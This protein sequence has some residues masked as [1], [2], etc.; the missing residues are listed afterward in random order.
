MNNSLCSTS[1]QPLT[2]P[3]CQNLGSVQLSLS[4]ILLI[5]DCRDGPP[6]PRESEVSDL[7]RSA[8][9]F[10]AH[11][12]RP[13]RPRGNQSHYQ[14]KFWVE[15]EQVSGGESWCSR[16]QRVSSLTGMRSLSVCKGMPSSVMIRKITSL[17]WSNINHSILMK[18]IQN[19]RSLNLERVF[20]VYP[21]FNWYTI[22]HENRAI[23]K[24]ISKHS[25]VFFT[26]L[27]GYYA[28]YQTLR[29]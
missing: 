22:N 18:V 2:P 6:I 16:D 21:F 5:V 29:P 7:L 11:C 10:A 15:E 12:T 17:I 13:H 8:S 28:V 24:V 27:W 23:I 3:Q 4:W 9:V 20:Q 26:G 14:G 25:L 19:D 1:T